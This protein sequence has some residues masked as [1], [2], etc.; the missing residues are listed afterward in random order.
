MRPVIHIILHFLIPVIVPYLFRLKH[1]L[2]VIAVLCSTIII[3]LDHLLADPIY[4]PNRSSIGFHP[5]HSY[6]A[7]GIYCLMLYI[8]KARL[9]AI[10]L[11]IHISLDYVDSLMM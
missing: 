3:D 8:P 5:L 4:D 11:L 6:Y 1:K 10:G 2:R 9:F 7:I